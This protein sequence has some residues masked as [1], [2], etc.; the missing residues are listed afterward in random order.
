MILLL[1]GCSDEVWL[2]AD[3]V[4]DAPGADPDAPFGDPEMAV[5]GVRGSGC[6]AGGTDVYSLQL[7][8]ERT[9]LLLAFA[10]PV[11]D[12]D[13]PDLV[14]FENPFEIQGGGVFMDPVVVEVSEDGETFVRFP[15]EAPDVYTSDP[16][17]W[18]GLAGLTPV[19]ANVDDPDAPLPEDP[20][21]GGDA[22]DLAELGLTAVTHVRLVV[23]DAI[24][25]DI[26]SNG[27]D[28]DGV[29]GRTL[30]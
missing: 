30:R 7:E 4:V 19:S 28:I 12:G 13:G 21:A 11:V 14:V 24:P 18:S 26:V 8:G 17:A 23:D 15:W 2:P 3:T 22:F 27:P 10:E 9:S 1:L 16:A 5:N 6:C 20:A 29:Y 25:Y